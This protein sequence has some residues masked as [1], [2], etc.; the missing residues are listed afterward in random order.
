MKYVQELLG[1]GGELVQ[2]TSK[3]SSNRKE[4]YCK[5]KNI[6]FFL[7]KKGKKNDLLRIKRSPDEIMLQNDDEL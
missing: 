6:T 2:A 3:E 1:A 4:I 7:K 5:T